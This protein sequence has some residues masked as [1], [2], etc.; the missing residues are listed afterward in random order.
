MTAWTPGGFP[1]ELF[2]IAREYGPPS[3]GQP[4]SEEWALEANVRERFDGLAA[5]FEIERRALRWEG[6]SPE[7]IAEEMADSTPTWVAARQALPAERF[8][9]LQ[10]RVV[11]LFRRW[12]G[13]GPV[14]IENEYVVIVARKRG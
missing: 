9:E 5:R 12:G 3:T 2:A 10:A 13:D 1:A 11:E 8:D 14:S 6:D 4:L 7:S